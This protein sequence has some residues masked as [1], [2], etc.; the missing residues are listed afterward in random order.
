MVSVIKIAGWWLTYPSEKWWSE[1]VSWDDEIPI[2]GKINNGSN[3]QP[4]CISHPYSGVN[5]N[6]SQGIRWIKSI[7]WPWHSPWNM[8]KLYSLNM[9]PSVQFFQGATWDLDSGVLRSNQIAC[10]CFFGG[11]IKG[12][13][14]L[15]AI[16][17]HQVL[18]SL[19]TS[20]NLVSSENRYENL[21]HFFHNVPLW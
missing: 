5:F 15:E 3:P 7:V 19:W 1:F 20:W 4:G 10:Q 18:H 21:G 12:C 13:S 16:K 2:Y 11:E 17:K 14:S 6:S 9:F 8:L